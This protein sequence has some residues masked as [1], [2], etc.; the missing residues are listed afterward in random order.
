MYCSDCAQQIL[1]GSIGKLWNIEGRAK[2]LFAA[3]AFVGWIGKCWYRVG[4]TLTDDAT[5]SIHPLHQQ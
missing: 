4:L 2:M 3:E 5:F 1:L